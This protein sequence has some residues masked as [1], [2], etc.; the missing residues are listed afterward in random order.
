MRAI[1]RLTIGIYA[2]FFCFGFLVAET[3][4]PL[5]GKDAP[6]TFSQMWEGFDPRNEELEVETLKQWEQ[7]DV[8]LRVIRYRIGVF[9]GTKAMMAGVYGFPK[10]QKGL[11]GLLQVHGGGQYAHHNAVLT[12][13][14]RGY[15]TLSIAWA[16]RLSATGYHVGPNEVKLFWEGNINDPKYKLTTDWG[17][18]DAYHAP[19]RY[20]KDAFPTIPSYEWSI[21]PVKSPRNNSWFLIALAGRRGLTFL[22]RQTEVDPDKLGV[23]GHSMGGKLTVLIS[24][25]DQRVKAAVPSCGGISDRYSEDDMHLAT[26]SDPP[27]LEKITAPIMFLSPS[28]DF[29]GRINDLETATG[30]IQSKHWRISSS[31]HHNHQDTAEFEVGTQLWFDQHLKKTFQMPSSPQAHLSLK[32]GS[33]PILSVTVDPSKEIESVDIYF[34]QQG[35]LQKKGAKDNS[36]NT[37]HRFWK[38]VQPSLGPKQNQ[39]ITEIPIFSIERP[40]WV[41]ANVQYQLDNAVEGAGY[42]YGTYKANHFTLSS[43]LQTA[44]STD[45]EKFGV[46]YDSQKDSMIENFRGSWRKDWFTYNPHKWGIRTNKLHEPKWHSETPMSR[47]SL[48]VKSTQPN[49]LVLCLDG[50]GTEINLVGNNLWQRFNL[51][52]EVFKNSD[53][54]SLQNWSTIK[55]LRFDHSD[56]LGINPGSKTKP[57]QVGGNW[58]GPPPE[59]R[60]LRWI[61]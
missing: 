52:K 33:F 4:P 54:E 21:D 15:A 40:L 60:N 43:L 48:E 5:N 20:G 50:Y 27:S 8:V 47:L 18:L 1:F 11:P 16:G 34:T 61:D 41:Y 45:L 10:G 39:W 2:S 44:S 3:L 51:P 42:Y 26:V 37:K 29:H 38:F 46:L 12:N 36:Q 9:K 6:S 59:F 31:P 17:A 13:A 24:G 35:V 30:E 49:P 32:E 19:S 53:G 14:K 25:A 55:E 58:E 28:N 22:E 57:V 56:K 23:Y 7:D